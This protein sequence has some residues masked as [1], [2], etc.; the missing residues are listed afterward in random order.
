MVLLPGCT[1]CGCS[2]ECCR[3]RYY[4]YYDTEPPGKWYD[5][6][7]NV[8]NCTEGDGAVLGDCANEVIEGY[9]VERFCKQSIEGK[10][11]HAV[12]REGSALDDYGT[13]A[14][15]DTG[16]SC[17]LLG[18]I[19]ADHDITDELEFEDDGTYLLAKVPIRMVNSQLG[20]PI[21]AAPVIICWCCV[22]PEDP[23]TPPAICPCCDGPPP[24]P[25]DKCCCIDGIPF[26]TAPN[27]CSGD[28][29]DEIAVAP[30]CY[31]AFDIEFSISWCGESIESR[32]TNWP[33]R[34]SWT[35]YNSPWVAQKQ[36]EGDIC[37]KSIVLN[38]PDADECVLR[39]VVTYVSF[40]LSSITVVCNGSKI[41]LRII[42]YVQTYSNGY[43]F[44]VS[45]DLYL[46]VATP[47][48]K[49]Y[50]F[51]H[52]GL[53]GTTTLELD[54]DNVT[55]GP[56]WCGYDGHYLCDGDD[57]LVT[58]TVTPKALAPA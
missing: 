4:G 1:C 19:D 45:D 43:T 51:E 47:W 10:D 7:P 29:K 42:G 54:L 52:D 12:L 21:G 27:G 6:C 25:P 55:T 18:Y 17:G 58:V 41:G 31:S 39:D 36:H 22:D 49:S 56:N 26:V 33:T 15:I 14:G 28:G 13:I 2:E 53:T 23:P 30:P 35:P 9:I 11:I 24:P 37:T 3:T 50:D 20:G 40:Y 57:P 46:G 38:P 5:E 44:R 34:S 32:N 16:E 48:I 8:G